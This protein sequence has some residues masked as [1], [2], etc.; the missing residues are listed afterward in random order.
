LFRLTHERN[1]YSLGRF[2]TWRN[3]LLDDVVDDIAA[4]KKLLKA[5]SAYDI[6]RAAA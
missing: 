6:R 3:I 1:I 5:N 4:I 2:A